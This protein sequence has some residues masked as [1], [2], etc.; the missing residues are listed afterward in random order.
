MAIL[1]GEIDIPTINGKTIELKIPEGTQ[2]GQIFR[3]KGYGMPSI[4]S[5]V[6]GNLYVEIFV[7]TPIKLSKKQKDLIKEFDES[8]DNNIPKTKSFFS[9]TKEFFK[10]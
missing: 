3:L 9:K 6:Y 5:S 4:R 8:I 1:G 7:E 2:T 10:N